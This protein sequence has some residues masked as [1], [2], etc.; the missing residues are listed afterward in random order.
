MLLGTAGLA[1]A[2]GCCGTAGLFVAGPELILWAM[3][4]DHAIPGRNM[5]NPPMTAAERQA[6]ADDAADGT[7]EMSPEQLLRMSTDGVGP[8]V[9]V[10]ELAVDAE[11]QLRLDVSIHSS[12]DRWLNIHS[13][14]DVEIDGGRVTRLVIDELEIGRYDLGQ[15]MRGQNVAAQTQQELDERAAVDPE[16]AARLAALQKVRIEGGKIVVELTPGGLDAFAAP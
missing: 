6:F 7:V 4:D 11:D 13:V 14:A 5:A 9:E 8:E 2:C 16:L 15:Y 1:L 3:F 10:L 12:A